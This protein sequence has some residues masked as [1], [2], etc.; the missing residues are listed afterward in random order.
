MVQFQTYNLTNYLQDTPHTTRYITALCAS[1]LLLL[2]ATAM[3]P[4]LLIRSK[5]RPLKAHGIA[6]Q[7]L[8]YFGYSYIML[9]FALFP[10][11]NRMLISLYLSFVGLL[12]VYPTLLR[13]AYCHK[14]IQLLLFF[15]KMCTPSKIL[16]TVNSIKNKLCA[17]HQKTEL[18]ELYHNPT[19]EYDIVMCEE[20]G[21]FTI[22]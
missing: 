22:S 19:H 6:F 4:L 17:L 15:Y 14:K 5:Y 11:M 18:C 2:L 13:F 1:G 16:W 12:F 9:Y 8:K 20:L 7:I 3:F 21:R 10:I